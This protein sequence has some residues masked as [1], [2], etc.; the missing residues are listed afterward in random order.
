[1]VTCPL[2]ACS[3]KLQPSW[4]PAFARMLF[5]PSPPAGGER[6]WFLRQLSPCLATFNALSPPHEEPHASHSRRRRDYRDLFLPPLDS[7]F[8]HGHLQLLRC[9]FRRHLL[10][11]FRWRPG[12]DARL[13]AL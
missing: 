1:I 12:A 4:I 7:H 5:P 6:A 13:L 2:P 8:L 3:Q 10:G 11:D 9:R